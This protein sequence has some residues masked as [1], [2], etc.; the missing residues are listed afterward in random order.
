MSDRRGMRTG[1]RRA[2]VEGVDNALELVLRE[3]LGQL[4]ACRRSTLT[5]EAQESRL[6]GR[7]LRL[8]W[9]RPAGGRDKQSD[10]RGR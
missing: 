7:T 1:E 5:R 9:S 10:V 3:P 4:T 6:R 8:S 2:D